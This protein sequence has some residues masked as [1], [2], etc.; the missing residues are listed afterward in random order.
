MTIKPL[1]TIAMGLVASISMTTSAPAQSQWSQP[2]QRQEQPQP[3]PQP[4]GKLPDRAFYVWAP[5][6]GGDVEMRSLDA[7]TTAYCKQ[8][9][10]RPTLNEPSQAG[11]LYELVF[12]SPATAATKHSFMGQWRSDG[13]FRAIRLVKNDGGAKATTLVT[14]E[15]G[16]AV[17]LLMISPPGAYGARS[18]GNC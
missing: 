16:A 2:P 18:G 5:S 15:L 17:W 10:W 4:P 7:L 13:A 11:G 8:L 6:K 9:G 12:S 1:A 14:D 3:Q